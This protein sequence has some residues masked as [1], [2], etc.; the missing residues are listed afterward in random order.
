VTHSDLN[1]LA[2]DYLMAVRTGEAEVDEFERRLGRISEHA[3][4]VGLDDDEAR[5]AFWLDVYNAGIVRAGDVDLTSGLTRWRHF[6]RPFIE[7]AGQRLSFDAIEHG[8]LRR[9]RW[10]LS[11][12]YLGNP[13]PGRFERAHRVERL[14]PRIHFALNCG[15]TSCPPIAA[16]DGDNLE[17][18]LEMATKNYLR[19]EVRTDGETLRVPA[20]LLWY[21]GDFGGPAGV[22]RLLRRSGIDG[23]Q[24]RI[25]FRAYDWRSTSDRWLGDR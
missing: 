11:L 13:A 10:L 20:I 23:W 4:R 17:G 15:A 2:I 14:D 8:L 3:L 19:A 18:Q 22:R 6:R 24:G 7:V 5:L 12:G 25:R 16:Y 21:I 9:S 1:A